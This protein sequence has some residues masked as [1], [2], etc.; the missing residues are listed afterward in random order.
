M[1]VKKMLQ[2]KRHVGHDKML[3]NKNKNCKKRFKTWKYTI[4]YDEIW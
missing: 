4:R 2:D 1:Q 3:Y